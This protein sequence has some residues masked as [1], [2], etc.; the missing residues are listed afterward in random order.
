MNTRARDHD[1]AWR[2]V[3]WATGREFLLRSA[4]EGNLNP[5]RAGIWDDQAFRSYTAAWGDFH[6]VARTLIERDAS[7]LVTP[8]SNYLAVATRWVE[9]L[10]DIHGGR[11]DA[12]GALERAAADIDA[13]VRE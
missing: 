9:A 3:E 5:T 8:A 7:V 12:G 10:L 4:F 2:F 6:E 11:S 1:E 13:L